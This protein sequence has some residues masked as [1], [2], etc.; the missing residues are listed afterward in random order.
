MINNL[1]SDGVTNIDVMVEYLTT[2]TCTD[3]IMDVYSAPADCTPECELTI[4]VADP[5]PVCSTLPIDLTAGASISSASLGGSWTSSGDGA[6]YAAAGDLVAGPPALFGA[7]VEYRPG[8]QDITNGDVTLTLTLTTN[9]PAGPCEP[10][11]ASVTVR[12]L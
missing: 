10:V 7:A 11:S 6:F 2:T 1:V 5:F 8:P 3:D 4:L 12:V 9:E